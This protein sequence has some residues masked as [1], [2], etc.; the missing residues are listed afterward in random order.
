M[1]TTLEHF[2]DLATQGKRSG[3]ST[4]ESAARELAMVFLDKG[5]SLDDAAVLGFIEF[6]AAA[7]QSPTSMRDAVGWSNDSL[8]D[9]HSAEHMETLDNMERTG[10]GFV[11]CLAA[12]WRRADPDNHAKLFSAFGDY[13]RQYQTKEGS[14]SK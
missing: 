6:M 5:L 13:Y 12:A 2:K 1:T 7:K 8:P 3:C 14:C 11:A 4:G 9:R 10:G